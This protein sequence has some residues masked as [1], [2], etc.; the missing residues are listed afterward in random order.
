MNKYMVVS[1]DITL[2]NNIYKGER[3]TP[4]EFGFGTMVHQQL[5]GSYLL[6]RFIEPLVESINQKY[7]DGDPLIVQ[8]GLAEELLSTKRFS[9][10]LQTYAVWQQILDQKNNPTSHWKRPLRIILRVW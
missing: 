7:P 6:H 9:S 10:A 5:G 4:D 2:D 3:S 8:Y 1:G